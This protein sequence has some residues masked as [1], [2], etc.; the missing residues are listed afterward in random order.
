VH[1]HSV[2]Q[3][4]PPSVCRTFSSFHNETLC[5]STIHS[6]FFLPGPW[7]LPFCLWFWLWHSHI[8][9]LIE[10]ESGRYLSF[11]TVSFTEHRVLKRHQN[12][13]PF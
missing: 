1:I 5:P 3:P 8:K 2:V 10:V 6:P 12:S 9:A 11:V 7:H 4:S 13:L